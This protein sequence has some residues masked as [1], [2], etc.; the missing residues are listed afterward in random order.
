[1]IWKKEQSSDVII[2]SDDVTHAYLGSNIV[3]ISKNLEALPH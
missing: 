1:M 3:D 2:K